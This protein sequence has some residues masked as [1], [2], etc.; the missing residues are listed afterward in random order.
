MHN[1]IIYEQQTRIAF[2][3]R[4]IETFHKM[5]ARNIIVFIYE[6]NKRQLIP[7]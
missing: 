4:I 3:E 2:H 7:F 1:F 6:K 5:L